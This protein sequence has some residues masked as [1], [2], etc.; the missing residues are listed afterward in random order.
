[1]STLLSTELTDGGRTAVPDEVLERLGVADGARV[2]WS[3]DGDRAWVSAEPA[4]PLAVRDVSELWARIGEAEEDVR[5]GRVSD[6]PDVM[7]R[8]RSRYSLAS[9]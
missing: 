3:I 6:L 1:M 5:A 2:Y 8:L 4:D 9:L 7:A